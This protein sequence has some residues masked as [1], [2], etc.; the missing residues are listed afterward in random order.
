[1]DKQSRTSELNAGIRSTIVQ[2]ANET[3]AACG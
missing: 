1:M 2:L 3:D